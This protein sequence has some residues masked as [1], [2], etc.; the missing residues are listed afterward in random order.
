MRPLNTGAWSW[1]NWQAK[2]WN[3]QAKH[4]SNHMD[5]KTQTRVRPETSPMYWIPRYQERL[6]LSQIEYRKQQD[7]VITPSRQE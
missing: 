5:I 4:W 2:H 6:T 3:W 1:R 7:G